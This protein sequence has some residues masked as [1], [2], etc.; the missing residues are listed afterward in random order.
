MLR[1]AQ[2]DRFTQTLI[3]RRLLITRYFRVHNTAIMI[4]REVSLQ[5]CQIDRIN[6][7]IYVLTC[8]FHSLIRNV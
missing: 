3:G 6:F 7:A 5:W 8:G 4:F 1:L 2:Y